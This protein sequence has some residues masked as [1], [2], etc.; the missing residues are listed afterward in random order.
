[1]LPDSGGVTTP[2]GPS[3]NRTTATA[4]DDGSGRRLPIALG[5]LAL[6]LVALVLGKAAIRRV[7]YATGDPR[8]LAEATRAEL[9]DVLR[10][11]GVRV[12]HDQDMSGVRIQLERTLGISGVALAE[13]HARARYGPP[14]GALEAARSARAEL[15]TLRGVLR[16]VL[17]PR[18]RLRGALS[19]RSLRRA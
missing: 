9:V 5:L 8:R 17:G 2:V 14:P 3:T 12:P 11:Q 10:D 13:A 6:P 7:R 4:A 1:V 16:E 18:R 15:R 19:L